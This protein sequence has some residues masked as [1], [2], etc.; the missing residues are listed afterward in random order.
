MFKSR[1]LSTLN[2]FVPW[3]TVSPNLFGAVSIEKINSKTIYNFEVDNLEWQSLQIDDKVFSRLHLKGIAGYEGIVSQI[4]APEIPVIR[5]YIKGEVQ[6]VPDES[7]QIL[8]QDQKDPLIP[9]QKPHEKVPFLT[10]EF[11]IDTSIYESTD[12]FPG[13]KLYTIEPSGSIRGVTQY[14]VTLYPVIYSPKTNTYK[15]VKNFK[16]YNEMPEITPDQRPE[17]LITVTGPK[18]ATSPALHL[19]EEHKRTLGF[20]VTRLNVLKGEKP[21][22][23]RAKIK[24]YYRENNLQFAVII[25]DQEDVPGKSSTIISGVTDHF[26]RAIDTEDY[27]RDINGPDIG[28]GRLSA[29]NEEQLATMVKK[30]IRYDLG[31]FTNTEWLREISWLATDDRWQIAEGSHNYVIKSYTQPNGY[32][33]IFP[34]ANQLGGDQLYAITHRVDSN[35]TVKTISRGRTIINYS[36]HGSQTSWAG[37]AVNQSDVKK[38]PRSEA[39]PFVISNACITGDFRVAES[40][41][42][43]WQRHEYGAIAF[44]GSMDSSYW[45]EDDILERRMFDGVFKNQ[46]ANFAHITDSAVGELWRHYGGQGLSSYYRETYVLFGDPSQNFRY[47][48]PQALDGDIPEQI[49]LGTNPMPLRFY[50]AEKPAQNVRVAITQADVLE[51]KT[52]FVGYTDA[53]GAI[54][55]PVKNI[56]AIP[57][58]LKISLSGKNLMTRIQTIEVKPQK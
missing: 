49:D 30:I 54:E 53:N 18:F 41:A 38:I 57:G 55:I 10:T 9:V 56:A 40:F 1:F 29:S 3:L 44:W 13:S 5:L 22:S 26:Y 36:G 11:S 21:E 45:D 23:I 19:Y 50:A 24:N 4:G 6:V 7:S 28:V 8:V 14:L 39:L 31:S 58:R 27:K 17:T 20:H 34:K 2:L 32:R 37:P 25:G 51:A 33:G 47:L 12:D 42:E 16:I 46:H 15:F 35:T 43:T 52:L 48:V